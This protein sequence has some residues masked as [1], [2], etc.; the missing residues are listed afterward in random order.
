MDAEPDV[1]SIVTV[2]PSTA[3]GLV[4]IILVVIPSVVD[5]ALK[6]REIPADAGCIAQSM[7]V[8]SDTKLLF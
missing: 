8:P 5:D 7:L 1:T 6:F 2:V 4:L 3:D